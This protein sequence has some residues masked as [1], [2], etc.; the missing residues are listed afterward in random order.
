MITKTIEKKLFGGREAVI[1]TVGWT[2]AYLLTTYVLE[3]TITSSNIISMFFGLAL[4][5]IF[6]ILFRNGW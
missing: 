4:I 1:V 5:L 3:R 6:S 2:G